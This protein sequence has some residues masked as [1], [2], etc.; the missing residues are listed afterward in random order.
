MTPA[1]PWGRFFVMTGA[2]ML[3]A[4][5]LEFDGLTRWWMVHVGVSLVGWASLWGR[6]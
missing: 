1:I 6:R 3:V 5:G 4:Y 2:S